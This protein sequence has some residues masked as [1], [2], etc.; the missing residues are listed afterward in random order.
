MTSQD[1]SCFQVSRDENGQLRHTIETLRLDDLPAGDVVIQVQWSSLNYKDALATQAHPGVVGELPHVPGIDAAGTVETSSDPRYQ[2]GDRV[3]VTGYE[4]GA[5]AWGGWSEYIRVPAEWVVALPNGLTPREAMV[6]GTA[7]FTAAQCVRELQLNG[8]AEGAVVVTGATGGVG[9]CAVRLLSTLGYEVH[10]VS[11][12]S[13]MRQSLLELGASDV[14][15]RALLEDNPERPLL[16]ARWAGGVD[17]VGG[18][19]LDALLKSTNIGGCVS[20][21]GLVAGDKLNLTVYPFILRGV[22]L[23]GVTSASCP[24][25]IREQVWKKLSTDWRIALPDDFVSEVELRHLAGAVQ[26][27]A[28]GENVGRTIIKVG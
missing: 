20:A 14:H 16:K 8:V 18:T 17:T 3:L 13:S 9:C 26:K 23:A 15:P 6:L 7:G 5:P 4:L 28:A 2:P 19:I 11:G 12:K 21:C 1:F 22:K 24:R 27:I 25:A 10:A